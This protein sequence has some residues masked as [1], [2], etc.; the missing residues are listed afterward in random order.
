[1][2]KKILSICGSPR[3]G[4]SESILL[5]IQEILKERGVDNE[6]VL[7][8]EKK[9]TPCHGCVEYCNSKLKCCLKDDMLEIMEKME[10]AD[11]LIFISPNY[12]K[13]PTGLFK[14]F[15]DRC[16]IFYTAGKEELFKKKRAA[17]I[18]V[19]TDVIE[20]INVCANNI[21]ENFCKAIG[22]N[23]VAVKSFQSHSEL[24]GNFNDIFESGISPNIEKDLK[25]LVNSLIL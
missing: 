5:R 23:V 18:A 19:G 12:F 7:L 10:K 6:I 15:I 13:M 2:N 24:K 21:S 8:R 14:N 3:K 11:G 4:N 22:L 17:V 9:I 1:M 16:S 20:G 25:K